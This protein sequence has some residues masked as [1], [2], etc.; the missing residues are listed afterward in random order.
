MKQSIDLTSYV[1]RTKNVQMDANSELISK[2][3]ND[4]QITRY[5]QKEYIPSNTTH[6]SI[7]H[8][9]IHISSKEAKSLCKLYSYF[10]L[11]IIRDLTKYLPNQLW[12]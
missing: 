10:L 9:T 1:F 8:C 5:L 3:P 11:T 2:T 4:M 6:I 12:G 7:G